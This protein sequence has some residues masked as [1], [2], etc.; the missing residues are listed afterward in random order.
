MNKKKVIGIVSFVV[1]IISASMLGYV[2]GK[3][4]CRPKYFNGNLI[5]DHGSN[6]PDIYLKELDENVLSSKQPII[7]DVIHVSTSRK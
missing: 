1:G 2:V 6:P 3:K 4:T 5:I 7:L